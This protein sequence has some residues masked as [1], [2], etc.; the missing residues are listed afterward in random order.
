MQR[1]GNLPDE[2]AISVIQASPASLDYQVE[3][4]PH[5]LHHLALRAAF[6]DLKAGGILSLDCSKCS[7]DTATAVLNL[8]PAAC[9]GS[10][11]QLRIQSLHPEAV[12]EAK[13][14]AF[15][16]ALEDAVR[17]GPP[18][19]CI[20]RVNIPANSLQGLLVALVANTSLQ[21]LK[22]SSIFVHHF[23]ARTIPGHIAD[24]GRRH[25]NVPSVFAENISELASLRRLILRN[26][27]SS[28]EVATQRVLVHSMQLPTLLTMLD[29][30]H[31][32]PVD[33]EILSSMIPALATLKS[34]SLC[35]WAD[36]DP[37]ADRLS[38]SIATLTT[39][40]SLT[41][42]EKDAL[43][44]WDPDRAHRV[45]PSIS[46]LTALKELDLAGCILDRSGVLQVLAAMP[47]LPLL[48][49]ISLKVTAVGT[50]TIATLE[51]L[52]AAGNCKKV[53]L[54]SV[55]QNLPD[56]VRGELICERLRS[57]TS[58][59]SLSLRS[60]SVSETPG[61]GINEALGALTGL[62]HLHLSHVFNTEPT[63]GIALGVLGRL[64]KLR[65]LELDDFLDKGKFGETDE[66][67]TDED[68]L[69]RGSRIHTVH[70]QMYQVP[71]QL[72]SFFARLTS[73]T[74]LRMVSC[75][76]SR[77]VFPAFCA[78][79]GCLTQLKDLNLTGI[80]QRTFHGYVAS[81][82][83]VAALK[84]LSQLKSLTISRCGFDFQ[85]GA[86]RTVIQG[87]GHLTTLTYLSLKRV[88]LDAVHSDSIVT[89]LCGLMNLE[90]LVLASCDVCDI[91]MSAIAEGIRGLPRLRVLD[92]TES[93]ITDQ[94]AEYLATAL[95]AVVSLRQVFIKKSSI[96][97]DGAKSLLATV[98][99]KDPTRCLDM[100]TACRYASRPTSF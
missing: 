59:E 38:A 47:R 90:V 29:F 66:A 54:Q 46:H 2:L 84:L 72:A 22:I 4:L 52:I 100:V 53:N 8:Y 36:S 10:P 21:N 91:C 32:G 20:E 65:Y 14:E 43:T 88:N 3:S 6:P 27:V 87:V 80:T 13:V 69:F 86:V 93:R 16:S 62:T 81:E 39:L 41:L 42:T 68:E 40:T 30:D 28:D 35:F 45:L 26:D 19:V 7:L 92:L 48:Q 67:N 55:W 70:L 18:D 96:R 98:G 79:L 83:L 74:E 77:G 37:I 61:R 9:S 1:L 60:C 95:Y 44:A 78:S 58:L 73:L 33:A 24:D 5:D 23:S 34:L 51:S 82:P 17:S 64:M 99:R 50:V 63:T 11:K 15:F 25:V 97:L 56:A 85:N 76:F 49:S 75:L 89:T 12:P 57:M 94:G 71:M 31:L